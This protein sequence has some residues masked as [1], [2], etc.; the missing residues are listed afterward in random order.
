MA[1]IETNCITC[2]KTF[3]IYPHQTDTA[4]Y[5]SREC[6]NF[7]V[8]KN[9]VNCGKEFSVKRSHAPRR[10]RC[11]RDCRKNPVIPCAQ[12]GKEFTYKQSQI[13][14]CSKVCYSLSQ[15]DSREANCKTCGKRF[16]YRKGRK[17]VKFCSVECYSL[18]N[19]KNGNRICLNCGEATPISEM[20]KS[21]KTKSG[22][23]ARCKKCQSKYSRERN[24]KRNFNLSESEYQSMFAAQKGCCAI[25]GKSRNSSGKKLAV[26]HCHK[27]G[28]VRGLLC[29]NCNLGLGSLQ[30]KIEILE[31][32]I[33]YLK[34]K[35]KSSSAV[36]SG[37]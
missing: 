12:C 21:S 30:D 28:K 2:D 8:T 20:S 11:S 33:N 31:S 19:Y 32:A 37:L 23:N 13:K 18:R 25:C 7:K 4:K 34:S 9:C 26:D 5:C 6:R 24:L 10:H 27:T 36:N 22:L 1:K 15:K 3:L 35:T 29:I 14:Y 17:N 16:E